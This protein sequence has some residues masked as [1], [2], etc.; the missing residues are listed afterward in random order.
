MPRAAS[1]MHLNLNRKFSVTPAG[2]AVGAD[3]NARAYLLH[4]VSLVLLL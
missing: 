4:D 3:H 2:S 1:C